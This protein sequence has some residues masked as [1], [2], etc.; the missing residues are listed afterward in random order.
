MKTI[1]TLLFLFIAACSSNPSYE[2]DTAYIEEASIEES[3]IQSKQAPEIQEE[4]EQKIIKTAN[5]SFEAKDLDKT[6]ARILQLVKNHKGIIQQDNA[7]KGYNRLSRYLTVRVP[8]ENFQ[9]FI[10][11]VSEGVAYF[12]QRNI[13]R[14]DVTEE[15]V[16]LEARLK[17]KRELERRYLELLNQAKNVKEI[18]DIERELSKIR[19]EIEARQGRLEYLKS[20]VSMST[21]TINFYKITSETGVTQSYG[22]KMINALKGGWDGISMFFIG[23]LYIWPIFI[24][25]LVLFIVIRWLIKRKKK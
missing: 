23:L 3:M 19:E 18:L 4:A 17:A 21:V 15:F 5:L 11:G 8:S 25:G 6:H 24:F 20:K 16:D 12:D 7:D 22:Q 10:N 14:Q 2:G 1:S 13:S 9:D